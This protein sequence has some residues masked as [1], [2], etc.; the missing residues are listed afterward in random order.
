VNLIAV[1][2]QLHMALSIYLVMQVLVCDGPLAAGYCQAGYLSDVGKS[3]IYAA[4]NKARQYLKLSFSQLRLAEDSWRV[5]S[6]S[7]Y[8]RWQY[9]A[10]AWASA[11]R[12][13]KYGLILLGWRQRWDWLH[14][15]FPEAI[16]S[17][18]NMSRSVCRA[19]HRRGIPH[20]RRPSCMAVFMSHW[21]MSLSL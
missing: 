4:I 21:K 14:R 12:S 1:N 5:L 16:Q 3:Y 10:T 8:F 9:Q 15:L 17:A 2:S 19:V 20:E 7:Q 11:H 18:N 13:L 6:R